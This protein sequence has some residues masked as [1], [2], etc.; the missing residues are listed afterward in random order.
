M[1]A[2]VGFRTLVVFQVAGDERRAVLLEGS[3]HQIAAD[4]YQE[5]R[6]SMY[7]LLVGIHLAHDAVRVPGVQMR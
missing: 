1:L 4:G 3:E 6:G 7:Q 5:L 2:Y